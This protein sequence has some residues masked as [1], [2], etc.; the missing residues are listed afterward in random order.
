MSTTAA[1]ALTLVALKHNTRYIS[2]HGRHS[3]S[4]ATQTTTTLFLVPQHILEK[5]PFYKSEL[6]SALSTKVTNQVPKIKDAKFPGAGQ[7]AFI[8][9]INLLGGTP[10]PVIDATESQ[11]ID[12]LKSLLT[13]YDVCMELQTEALEHAVL[14]HMS[15]YQYPK[16]DTFVAFAREVF[17][18]TG[19]EKRAVDSSI[20]KV[21]KR[22][23][24]E[25]LPRLLQEGDAKKIIEM[26]GVLSTELFDVVVG[27]SSGATQVEGDIKTE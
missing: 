9:T 12:T 23:L 27:N 1:L 2:Y 5:I 10:L 6:E 20:G 18:D 19:L 3:S 11:D 15:D 22:K 17:G 13:V 4:T 16:L 8:T 14:D 7:E 21:I 25:L 26:G 24:V